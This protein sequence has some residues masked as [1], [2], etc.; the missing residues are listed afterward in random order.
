MESAS[1]NSMIHVSVCGY[2]SSMVALVCNL[3][4]FFFLSI[5]EYKW[6]EKLLFFFLPIITL[7]QPQ[8]W[9]SWAPLKCLQASSGP[10]FPWASSSFFALTMTTAG[11]VHEASCQQKQTHIHTYAWTHKRH[12]TTR[13]D[14]RLFNICVI[15]V[16]WRGVKCWYCVNW[17]VFY[18]WLPEVSFKVNAYSSCWHKGKFPLCLYLYPGHLN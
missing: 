7:K 17:L 12:H 14:E 5:T 6:E 10:R 3:L 11:S 15:T 9:V 13:R 16:C 1:Q 2:I 18:D 8:F 4:T